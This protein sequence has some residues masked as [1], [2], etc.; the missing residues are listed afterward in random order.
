MPLIK[1]MRRGQMQKGKDKEPCF[2]Y[3][4]LERPD[5]QSSTDQEPEFR[6]EEKARNRLLNRQHVVTGHRRH[7]MRSYMECDKN[8]KEPRIEPGETLMFKGGLSCSDNKRD[9]VR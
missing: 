4:P 7:G 3:V 9:G 8:I 2:N 6:E 1:N 5:G